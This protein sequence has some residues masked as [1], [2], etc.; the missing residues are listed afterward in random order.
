MR[1][2]FKWLGIVLGVLVGLLLAVGLV[3]YIMGSAQLSKTRQVQPAALVVPDD[4][5]ALARGAHLVNI[6][7]KSCHG[8]GLSGAVLLNDPMIGKVYAPNITGLKDR[9]TEEELVLAIRHAIGL[10]QVGGYMKVQENR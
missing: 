7:C 3:L 9:R 6:A 8:D 1:K 2:F 5:D 10:L 4:E